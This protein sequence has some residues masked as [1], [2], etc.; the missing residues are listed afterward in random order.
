[1]V[2]SS[3]GQGNPFEFLMNS[4]K[5]APMMINKEEIMMS[6]RKNIEALTEA[7]KMALDV[8]KNVAQLQQQYIKQAFETMTTMMREVMAAPMN[9]EGHMSKNSEHMKKHL[10]TAVDHTASVVNIIAKTHK[11][12]HEKMKG[13]FSE[14]TKEMQSM[15][16]PAQDSGKSKA[17]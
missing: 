13:R 8:M 15:H 17:N 16:K 12:I 1:M 5:S 3:S 9:H 11:D 7:N 14:C 10:T 2:H 6:H 4:M